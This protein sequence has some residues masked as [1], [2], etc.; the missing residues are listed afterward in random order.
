MSRVVCAV[1]FSMNCLQL[2]VRGRTGTI[3]ARE[4]ALPAEAIDDGKILQPVAVQ[5][6][7]TRLLKDLTVTSPE[8]RVAISDSACVT[9]FV[10]YPRMPS[11]E[12]ARSLEFEASRELPM[13]RR[14]AYLGW[15][16]V[17]EEDRQ[18]TVML[19]AAWRDVVEGYL[20]ALEGL[21]TVSVAEPRSSALA[22]AAARSDAVLIDWSG[23]RIQV[24][25]VERRR[26]S[27]TTSALLAD[28][29]ERSVNRIAH[30]AATMLPKASSRNGA[31]PSP[32][33]FLGRL[34]GREDI[35]PPLRQAA[36]ISGEILVDWVLSK[37]YGQVADVDQPANIG[38]LM[39]N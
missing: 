22:R 20:A 3:H 31:L 38:L 30:V 9:K 37:P 23:A 25:V 12:L 19:V 24:A 8:F 28:G 5:L 4:V 1:D 6:F 26:V 35:V 29:A 34:R 16:V 2:L 36:G 33:I 10:S 11:R 15:N 17:G 7:L 21:G 18:L 14:D 32:V 13:N 27:Y 39:R